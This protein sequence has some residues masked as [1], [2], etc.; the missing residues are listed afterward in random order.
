MD[1]IFDS[2]YRKDSLSLLIEAGVE[3][4]KAVTLI[5]EKFIKALT[6]ETAL[7]LEDMAKN[8]REGKSLEAVLSDNTR[9]KE[10][11]GFGTLSDVATQ[12]SQ[13]QSYVNKK[14][15][16]ADNSNIKVKK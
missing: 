16:E 10:K 14:K 8:V 2:E 1:R 15:E 4:E 12:L 13:L 7:T 11:T 6:E 3:K 9:L 5:T